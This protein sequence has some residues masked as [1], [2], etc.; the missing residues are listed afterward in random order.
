MSSIFCVFRLESICAVLLFIKRPKKG[1]EKFYGKDFHFGKL[2]ILEHF[3]LALQR[4]FKL[5]VST[6]HFL[7]TFDTGSQ[8][9]GG[10]EIGEQRFVLGLWAEKRTVN[11]LQIIW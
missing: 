2:H 1:R 5:V 3:L 6:L 8:P 4:S 9:V 10:F 11:L 7:N